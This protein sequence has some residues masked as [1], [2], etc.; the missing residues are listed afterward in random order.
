MSDS[1]SPDSVPGDP[2]DGE[3]DLDALLE[4]ISESAADLTDELGR[5]GPADAGPPSS[6]PVAAEG[7]TP[8]S[9]EAQLDEIESLLECANDDLGA[10]EDPDVAAP[11]AGESTVEPPQLADP[12]EPVEVPSSPEPDATAPA[13][14]PSDAPPIGD[15]PGEPSAVDKDLEDLGLDDADVPGLDDPS[16]P[17]PEPPDGALSST[18]LTSAEEKAAAPPAVHATGPSDDLDDDA[19][20]SNGEA[21]PSRMPAIVRR[22]QG[23][24]IRL[25]DRMLDLVDLIDRPF[26]WVKPTARTLI[27][28]AALATLFAAFMI[29]ILGRHAWIRPPLLEAPRNRTVVTDQTRLSD[30]IH[31]SCPAVG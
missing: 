30:V 29:F 17:D 27:G 10:D 3:Q 28:W 8:E 12:P 18:D 31:L 11:D 15:A 19:T 20:K 4:D 22:L 23:V 6:P 7:E 25:L 21:A 24:L 26:G 5:S 9:I 14:E 2:V 1:S 16:N 13:P